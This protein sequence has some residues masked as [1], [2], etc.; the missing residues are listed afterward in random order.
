M[1]SEDKD[2]SEQS[3]SE[4]KIFTLE[5]REE[6]ALSEVESMLDR[7]IQD[8]MP[9]TPAIDFTDIEEWINTKPLSLEMLKEKVIMLAFWAY[10][11]IFCLRTIPIER[12]LY[13]KYS[14]YGFVVVGVHCAEYDFATNVSNV[15]KAIERYHVNFPVGVDKENKTWKTYGNMYWPKHVLIDAMGMVRYEIAGF[16]HIRDYELPIYGLLREAG[17][18]PAP[19]FEEEDPRDEIYDTYG[20]HFIAADRETWDSIVHPVCVG[21]TKLE[22]F[23]NI[24]GVEKNK[25]NEF[26]DPG[27]HVPNT[28]YLQGKWFWDKE[29]IRFSGKADDRA[30]IIMRYNARRANAIMGT[31]DGRPATIEVKID[32]NYVAQKNIGSDIELRDSVS[33][34]NVEWNHVHNLIKTEQAETHEIEIIPRSDNFIFYTFLFG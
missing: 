24:Q 20:T 7:E 22:H 21:Y 1:K 28:V 30:A 16:N 6:I 12:M 19:Y 29:C 14:E 8:V 4:S 26:K 23:G 3:K 32:G 31:L 27:Q 18:H 10:T 13:K 5:E 2:L 11:D 15:R 34:V 33:Y 9:E 25:I 17:Q